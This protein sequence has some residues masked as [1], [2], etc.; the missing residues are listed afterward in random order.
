MP[1]LLGDTPNT[2]IEN[3]TYYICIYYSFYTFNI[4]YYYVFFAYIINIIYALYMHY[5]RLYDE[6][7]SF[8]GVIFD[9][10]IVFSL[11]FITK[12]V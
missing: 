3:N 1:S 10:Y 5:I 7:L 12:V 6:S 11:T 2:L 9:I 4:C 8:Y